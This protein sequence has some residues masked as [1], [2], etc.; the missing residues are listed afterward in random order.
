MQPLVSVIIN[1][2]DSE[3]YLHQA[4][5]SVYAQVF[6]DWEIIFFDNNS[7]DGSAGIAKSYDEKLKYYKNEQTV[8]LGAA[9]NLAVQ[10]ASGKYIAFLDCDDVWLP[11]KLEKQVKS[12]SQPLFNQREI[13]LSY[14]DAMRIDEN[15]NHLIPYS[16]ERNLF[17]GNVYIALINNCFIACSACMILR[18]VF[19]QVSGFNPIY[20]QVEDLDLWIRIARDFD[21]ALVDEQ[22]TELRMHS[23][24]QSRKIYQV[25]REHKQ[26]ALALKREDVGVVV[27]CNYMLYIVAVKMR[28]IEFFKLLP[29]RPIGAVLK[30]IALMIML[31]SH[32]VFTYRLLLKHLNCNMIKLFHRKFFARTN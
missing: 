24:N 14:T 29:A 5:D 26:L 22:L 21:V 9:R 28:V 19:I 7:S 6:T 3:N 13:G 2:F 16:Y 8:P 17:A 20:S 31:F 18:S 12:F 11:T 4:I 30:F 23:G 1:C 10:L 27:E 15:S 32:P 25:M